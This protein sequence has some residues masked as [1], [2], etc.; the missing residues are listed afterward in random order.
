[1]EAAL[2]ARS[3]LAAGLLQPL[4]ENSRPGHQLSTVALYPGIGFVNSNTATGLRVCLYDDGIGSRNTGKER[5]AETGLDYFGARYF[6]G[7]QGRFT[8]PDEFGGVGG[9]YPV[10][11]SRPTK[12]GPLPYADI[13]NPQSLNK[14]TYALNNPLRFIDPDGHQEAQAAEALDA[15]APVVETCAETPGSCGQAIQGLAEDAVAYAQR[16]GSDLAKA[17]QGLEDAAQ[18]FTG[19]FKNTQRIMQGTANGANFRVPDFLNKAGSFLGEVKDTAKLGLTKQLG[20]F[21]SYAKDQGLQ[22]NLFVRQGVQLSQGLLGQI[23]SSGAKVYQYVDKKWVDVTAETLKK[24]K[25]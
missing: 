13:A 4:S 5:D 7:A 6:S 19:L 12:P 8:S 23:Q 1:M 15:A 17:G 16:A 22:V 11:G 24:L 18:S 14:Y 21:F 20:D 25:N 2:H 10:G 9:A 3:L